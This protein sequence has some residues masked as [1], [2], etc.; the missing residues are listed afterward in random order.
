M[1]NLEKWRFC[2]KDLVSP[3]TFVDW[4]F[5]FVIGAAL[6]RRVWVSSGMFELYPNLYIVFTGPPGVGKGLVLRAIKNL[7]KKHKYNPHKQILKGADMGAKIT[8]EDLSEFTKSIGTVGTS[9]RG[10]DGRKK[11]KLPDLFPSAPDN[12]TFS[13]LVRAFTDNVRSLQIPKVDE[14]GKKYMEW[15]HHCSMYCALEEVSSLFERHAH[16]IHNFFISAYDSTRYERST[17]MHGEE[18]IDRICLSFIG[19]T[20]PDFVKDSFDNKLFN[21]GFASR[22]HF[23]FAE[24][25]RFRRLMIPP[26]DKEQEAAWKDLERYTK[27]LG[28]QYGQVQ[29][30][31][32]AYDFL[33]DWWEAEEGVIVSGV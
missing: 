19:G 29:F 33:C 27:K 21:Q 16:E 8:Y 17:R 18:H 31:K 28:E 5:Y 3:D 15:Y 1:T 2:L 26:M 20:Q 30:T 25:P 24:K 9:M 32:E 12:T 6:Q 10:P 14:E 11:T 4:G 13:D 22:T 23:L 7:L